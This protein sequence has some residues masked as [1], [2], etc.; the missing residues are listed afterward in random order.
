MAENP[1][2]IR[3]V[4]VDDNADTLNNL[5]KLLYFEK[6][7]EIIATASSG[8]EAIKVANERQP[9]VILMDINMPGMDGMEAARRIRNLPGEAASVAIVALTADVMTHHQQAYYAAGMNG[10][11]PKPFSP[12]DLLTEIAR[13]AS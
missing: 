1:S 5:R 2:K 6:D 12:A 9:D 3:L 4:V 13:L 11:V 7:I 10:F 8:D